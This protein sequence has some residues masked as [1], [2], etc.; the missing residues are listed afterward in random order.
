MRDICSMFWVRLETA[1]GPNGC[2]A[3][4]T[5]RAKARVITHRTLTLHLTLHLTYTTPDPAPIE[6]RRSGKA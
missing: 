2:H 1:N 4:L 3:G 5:D 6:S